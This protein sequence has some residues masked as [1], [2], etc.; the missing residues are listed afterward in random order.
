MGA[1]LLT[2]YTAEADAGVFAGPD[3]VPPSTS[4]P[5][6]EGPPVGSL[7]E[8]GCGS[9]TPP[10]LPGSANS[11]HSSTPPAEVPPPALAAFGSQVMPE[12]SSAKVSAVDPKMSVTADTLTAPGRASQPGGS[13][14]PTT[15]ATGGGMSHGSA[16]AS[17]SQV[18]SVASSVSESVSQRSSGEVCIAMDGAL[19]SPP[20]RRDSNGGVSA[21]VRAIPRPMW[22]S[23][24]MDSRGAS[25]R[26]ATLDVFQT[27][28]GNM[29][30]SGA[31][32][33]TPDYSTQS[34]DLRKG[35]VGG[36]VASVGPSF[37]KD[38]AGF[39][40][41]GGRPVGEQQRPRSGLSAAVV[42]SN[43]FCM[44]TASRKISKPWTMGWIYNLVL[45]YR[46]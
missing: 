18:G 19:L 46:C 34:G 11:S 40:A 35:V 8:S 16:N 20:S 37:P 25:P 24:S 31:V 38:P 26:D 2:K 5:A 4:N 21:A 30:G 12:T 39:S 33:S 43:P 6:P 22:W 15:G 1:L 29:S 42:V 32:A 27:P 10:P 7:V 13:P 17:P 36:A 28:P 23:G 44:A 3:A 14:Q 45:T 9:C 41:G